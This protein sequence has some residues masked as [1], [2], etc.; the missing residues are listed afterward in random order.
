MRLVAQRHESGRK[1]LIFERGADS[2]HENQ[3]IK[4]AK[5]MKDSFESITLFSES[6]EQVV[7]GR[8]WER[9]TAVLVFVRH[10]G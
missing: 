3:A 4:E 9:Q 7:M 2:G 6:G 8:L 10:L 1:M 5:T